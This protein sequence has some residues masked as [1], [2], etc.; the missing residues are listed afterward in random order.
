MNDDDD[1]QPVPQVA[2]VPLPPITTQVQNAFH[3]GR[4]SGYEEGARDAA[5][6]MGVGGL[7]LVAVG[8]FCYYCWPATTNAA[9]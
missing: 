6:F 8:F 9:K 3:A 4:Q 2:E 5:A 1:K 7:A